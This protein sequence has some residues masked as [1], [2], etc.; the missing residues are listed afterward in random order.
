MDGYILLYRKAEDNPV[1]QCDVFDKYHAWVWLLERANHKTRRIPFNGGYRTIKRGQLLTSIRKLATTWG[2]GKDRVRIFLNSLEMNGM[3][4]QKRDTSGTLLT[5]VNYSVYQV[6][7]DTNKDADR[8]A[9]RYTD[10]YTNQ[11][12]T[13]KRNRTVAEPLERGPLRDSNDP[14]YLDLPVPEAESLFSSEEEEREFRERHK[15]I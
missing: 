13:I 11:T 2:W 6:A 8:Y 7:P 5:I 3:I 15:K 4:R 1:L 12:Q 9:N 14:R 10:R